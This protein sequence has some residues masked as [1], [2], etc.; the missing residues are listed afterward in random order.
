[1][2][3]EQ[4][5]DSRDDKA[6]EDEF[7]DEAHDR[8]QMASDYEEKNRSAAK[9]DLNMLAGDQWPAEV[10]EGRTRDKRPMLTIN[11]LP[12]HAEQ[13]IAESRLNRLSIKVRPTALH[14][15]DG[16]NKPEEIAEILNGMIRNIENASQA[17]SVYQHGQEGAVNNGFGYFA[18]TTEY[19]DDDTFEQDIRLRRILNPFTVY[20]DPQ[21]EEADGSD[22]NWVFR[23][24]MILRGE[25]EKL[26][27][28][29][30]PPSHWE[31]SAGDEAAY[32]ITKDT[33]RIAAYWVKRP[34]E[35]KIVALSDGRV[36]EESVWRQVQD[37]MALMGDAATPKDEPPLTVVRERTVKA[38]VVVLYIIDGHQI[39]EGPRHDN[40]KFILDFK[41]EKDIRT[42]DGSYRDYVWPG[43]Y[44]PIVPVWGKE[45]I[46]DGRRVLSGV[47]RHAKD[48]QRMVNYHM[49]AEVEN[50][51]LAKLPPVMLTS[52]QLGEHEALWRSK[53]NEPYLLYEH[54]GLAPPP[55]FPQRAQ[56]SFGN[57]NLISMCLDA[58]NATTGGPRSSELPGSASGR[59][60]IQRNRESDVSN[61]RIHD[62]LRR[63]VEHAG[64]ILVDLIPK[65]Y[66]TDRQ[67][68]VL[69]EE[70]RESFVGI[71]QSVPDSNVILNDL[72]QGKYAVTVTAGPHFATQRMETVEALTKLAGSIREPKASMIFVS[73]VVANMDFPGARKMGDALQKMLPPGTFDKPGEEP[74][75]QPP[76]PE[77][78]L[79]EAEVETERMKAKKLEAE[80]ALTE[81]KTAQIVAETDESVKQIAEAGA[82][83]A[84]SVREGGGG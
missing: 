37:D 34:I 57:I 76:D 16:E 35:K 18:V 84:R 26:Y 82:Q 23:S 33:V 9:D 63:A 70:G 28:K 81:A 38:H 22:A 3:R 1:M 49:S 45:L 4:V 17:T 42:A 77:A 36:V 19:S 5:V 43:K 48:S 79:K 6:D 31:G 62:N 27:P 73:E 24:E 8:F 60:L 51:A 47:I 29:A 64:R 74:T 55:S 14:K 44:I 59:A 11:R 75:E 67:V 69:N 65:I 54:D 56:P 10:M 52:I 72:T 78:V 15:T 83:G 7:L 68:A 41:D 32:W 13:P 46:L 50:V 53:G 30:D 71:N 80:V 2:A 61:F 39:I 20:F 21:H 25:F 66:D 12:S 58:L 40:G